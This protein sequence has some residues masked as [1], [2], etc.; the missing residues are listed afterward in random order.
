MEYPE[1]GE[2]SVLKNEIID[3]YTQ[4]YLTIMNHP[5]QDWCTSTLYVDAFAGAPENRLRGTKE[6]VP[7]S[8]K[9]AL[10]WMPG[11]SEYYFVD[12]DP[13]RAQLLR[14]LAQDRPDVT[15]FNED[16]NSVL[17]SHIVPRL[18]R[19]YKRR[20]FVLLDPY[21]LQLDWNVVKSLGFTNSA[22]VAINFPTMDIN[23]NAARRDPLAL[24]E[25]DA[26][27]MT[28]WWG[29]E[30]WKEQFY[31]KGPRLLVGEPKIQKTVN[32]EDIVDLYRTR[33]LNE[34]KFRFVTQPFET[35]NKKNATL[36]YLLLASNNETAVRIMDEILDKYRKPRNLLLF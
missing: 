29:S 27:R 30:I 5:N 23:R 8:A 11:F 7:G 17:M 32:N 26:L 4:A 2:W 34:G 19:Q 10:S 25:I 9:R 22:D 21:G 36:Y 14:E 24:N 35:T 31:G 3:K 12:A 15:V 28:K 1:I 33:L 16:G 6:I 20:G 18:Q 13:V